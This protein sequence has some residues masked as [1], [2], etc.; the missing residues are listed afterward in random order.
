MSKV[1]HRTTIAHV[2][3]RPGER[4]PRAG[5]TCDDFHDLYN[6]V[7]ALEDLMEGIVPLLTAWQDEV[8][9]LRRSPVLRAS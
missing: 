4:E 7:G 5:F 9:Q 3:T 8:T 1:H 2:V 6:R